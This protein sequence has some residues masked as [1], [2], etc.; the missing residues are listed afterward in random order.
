[1]S[2]LTVNGSPVAIAS[3]TRSTYGTW[4]A[5]VVMPS[6]ATIA[7]PCTLAI[8]DL[9]VSGT[10][11][12]QAGFNG[13]RSARIV[14]GRGGW[15]TELPAKG[16]SHAAGVKL[17]TIVGD[18]ARECGETIVVT[19]DRT[20]GSHWARERAKA[21]RVI[22]FLLD[23]QWWVD[24]DGV[25]QTKARDASIIS[26]PF[27]V[28]NYVG[29]RGLFEIATDSVASW[30]P[31]RTFTAPG[32]SGV[33]TIS[34]VT[35]DV[36]NEGKARLHVLNTDGALERLRTDLR[37]IVRSETPSLSY[38]G[39]WEYTIASGDDETVDVKSSDNRMPDLT[40]VPMM[41]GLMGEVVTP[42][43]GSKCRIM[44]VNCDP[45]RP[46]CTGIVGTPTK[47]VIAD[48]LPTQ[49]AARAGDPVAGAA[50]GAP[51]SLKVFI[52]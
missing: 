44:F 32:V 35:I 26:A 52:G 1:M 29:S 20:I 9:S 12:R 27:T 50:I 28:I 15:R 2:S 4:T 45:S 31:G 17:S 43:P 7:N 37:S 13:D 46:E 42:A 16:Y 49:G 38:S 24:D 8:G 19:S 36:S 18:A 11:I 39:V 5:D 23:G 21:E 22:H 33:Q 47:I 3:F 34:S 14:G 10:V 51:T 25:T 30:Q 6:D 41:P 48:G 40:K